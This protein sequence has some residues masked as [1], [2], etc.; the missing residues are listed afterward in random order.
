MATRAD[1]SARLCLQLFLIVVAYSLQIQEL[2]HGLLHIRQ[3]ARTTTAIYKL[4]VVFGESGPADDDAVHSSVAAIKKIFQEKGDLVGQELILARLARIQE[5]YDEIIRNRNKHGLFNFI[6]DIGSTL[7]GFGTDQDI[8]ELKAVIS[9]NHDQVSKVIHSNNELVSIVNATRYK[10]DANRLAINQLI[11]V[12]SLLKSFVEDVQLRSQMHKGIILKLDILQ[13]HVNSIRRIEDKMLR[14]R[15]DLEKGILSEDLLPVGSLESLINSPLIPAGSEFIT[16][17][18]WYYS[19]LHVTLVS[20]G[21]ELV[22]TVNLPLVSPELVIATT[23]KS[24]PTPNLVKNVTIQIQVAGS[25][26]L[27]SQTGQV[28]DIT[29]QCVGD[30]PMVCPTVP[31]RRNGAGPKSC[32][33]ALLSN[34]DVSDYC[35]VDVVNVDLGDQFIYHSIN[36]F[37]LVTWGTEIVEECLKPNHKSLSP[38]TYLVEWNGQ[39]SL[40]TTDH[41]IQGTVITGSSLR[42]NNTWKALK[43]PTIS[44]FTNMK[45]AN[46]M[47]V[48]TRLTAIKHLS[49]S[50]LT[51]VE[52]TAIVWST[53]HSFSITTIIVALVAV[54]T[55]VLCVVFFIYGQKRRA[56]SPA[57]TKATSAIELNELEEKVGL[58]IPPLEMPQ[59]A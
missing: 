37:V 52:P 57:Q 30:Q 45:L 35:S 47:N 33:S 22:Y 40:C 23:F 20:I 17:L 8:H 11:N 27:N 21:N 51:M 59:I 5:Q 50:K 15:K 42:L 58:H 7:F 25:S 4:V 49:L 48:P 16:P 2:P 43:I 18:R 12:T 53:N 41:C 55:L 26:I 36:S 3:P 32:Q 31:V 13:D 39:C 29:N 9:R 38:G 34:V 6:G 54:I 10:M 28:T 56:G 14:M 19:G 1:F 44:K 24:F 46:N